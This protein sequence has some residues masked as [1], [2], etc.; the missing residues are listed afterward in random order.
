[1]SDSNKI[2]FITC[3]N[4]EECYAESLLYLKNLVIP[5]GMDTE[6]LP[7]RG[8]KSMTSGYN[9][10]MKMT[11]A[12][13]KVYLHQDIFLMKKDYVDILLKIFQ[14]D[15]KIGLIGHAGAHKLPTSGVW[16]QGEELYG[17]VAHSYEP[18]SLRRTDYGCHVEGDFLDLEVVDGLIMATQYDIPWREELFTG[19]HFYDISQSFEFKRNGLRV[20]IPRQ[21]DIWCVHACG[22]K[23]L[24]DDYWRYRQI[25]LNE[26]KKELLD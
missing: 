17:R 14:T 2:C 3:V 4:D 1:M 7:I 22:N 10:A 19:W 16:W 15:E 18:E 11:N 26:Y 5:Q 20:V 13:Y 6:F 24:K 9:A 12:K 23:E 8:A 21:D 25:F